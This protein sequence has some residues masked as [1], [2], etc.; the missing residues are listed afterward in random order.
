[1][2][3]EPRLVVLFS[4]KLLP[5]LSLHR[6]PQSYFIFLSPNGLR[7]QELLLVHGLDH[8]LLKGRL[9]LRKDAGDSKADHSTV[10]S[11]LCLLQAGLPSKEV[12]SMTATLLCEH[13]MGSDVQKWV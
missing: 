8:K 3:V 11:P 9:P 4:L 2:G 10:S 13:L 6:D 12:A 1:M 5:P 7:A